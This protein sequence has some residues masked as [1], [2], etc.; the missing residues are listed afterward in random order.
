MALIS[1]KSAPNASNTLNQSQPLS[2]CL[3]MISE[4]SP[5]LNDPRMISEK[6]PD[7]NDPRMISEKSPDLKNKID[8]KSDTIFSP[9]IHA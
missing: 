3:R 7:W 5:D 6:S 2:S 8:C 4:K 9:S 1:P